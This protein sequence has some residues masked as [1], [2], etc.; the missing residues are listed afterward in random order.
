MYYSHN[1]LLPSFDASVSEFFKSKGIRKRHFIFKIKKFA[2]YFSFKREDD[3]ISFSVYPTRLFH[4]AGP[5]MEIRDLHLRN[6]IC[7]LL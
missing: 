1:T 5:L 2:F 3:R 6:L 4:I 7:G